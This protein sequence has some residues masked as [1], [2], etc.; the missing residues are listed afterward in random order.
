MNLKILLSSTLLL[1]VSLL[2]VGCQKEDSLNSTKD[3]I[4]WP[5]LISQ[6]TFNESYIDEFTLPNSWFQNYIDTKTNWSLFYNWDNQY[7][8]SFNEEWKYPTISITFENINSNLTSVIH[9][10]DIEVIQSEW[11]NWDRTFGRVNIPKLWLVWTY[12]WFALKKEK[13]GN[14]YQ[15]SLL[16]CWGK[17]EMDESKAFPYWTWVIEFSKDHTYA[18]NNHVQTWWTIDASKF[19]N[20]IITTY[21]NFPN[22][23]IIDI[24]KVSNSKYLKELPIK[25]W[26]SFSNWVI[27]ILK[28]NEWN[29][30]CKGY[31]SQDSNEILFTNSEIICWLTIQQGMKFEKLYIK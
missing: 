21:Q 15:Y 2:L 20:M 9:E 11:E 13:N 6:W 28:D 7:T 1:V 22:E 3:S 29:L 23:C 8:Y 17:N 19:F 4:I 16:N 18:Y 14:W 31:S 24:D 10:E 30:F 26:D 12:N 25:L 27:A 5:Q